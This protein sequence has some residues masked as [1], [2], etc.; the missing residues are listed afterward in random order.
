SGFGLGAGDKCPARVPLCPATS[1][2]PATVAPPL[3]TQ[4]GTSE[5]DTDAWRRAG[6]PRVDRDCGGDRRLP[7]H[8]PPT[9]V[10]GC[11]SPRIRVSSSREAPHGGHVDPW[12]LIARYEP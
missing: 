9:T 7:R 5:G 8:V 10:T 3:C 12:V 1:G 6:A 11:T 2:E 4:S